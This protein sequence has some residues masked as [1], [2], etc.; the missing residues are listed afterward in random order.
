MRLI[1]CGR[2]NART[3]ARARARA[4]LRVVRRDNRRV[5]RGPRVPLDIQ[6]TTAK[7]ALQFPGQHGDFS[8][9]DNANARTRARARARASAR[10]TLRQKTGALRPN[11]TLGIPSVTAKGALRS[12]S[13]HGDCLIVDYT[14]R[15]RARTRARA[16]L[17]VVRYGSKRVRRGLMLTWRSHRSPLK[18]HF[19]SQANMATLLLWTIQRADARARLR[20][21][22]CGSKRARRGPMLTWKSHRPPLREHFSFQANMPTFVLWTIQRARASAR[23]TM[24]Q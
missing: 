14:T 12:T 24:R 2:Y 6:S 1:Y 5:R 21:V 13:Q 15:G 22:R 19:S 11:V 23:C 8:I 3:R 10:C 9:V 16:R 4:R 7:G 20:V 18:E 17:R